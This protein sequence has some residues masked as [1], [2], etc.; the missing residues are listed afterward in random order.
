VG[1]VVFQPKL[2]TV[3]ELQE[4][5]YWSRKQLSS[6]RSIAKRTFHLRKSS[7]LY[8]PINFV[9]RKASRATLKEAANNNIYTGL[10]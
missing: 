2:L 5:Y 7:L 8:I 1:E 9:M 4:G 6:L 10:F 3:D